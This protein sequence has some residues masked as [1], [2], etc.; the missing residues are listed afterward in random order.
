MT[1]EHL[2]LKCDSEKKSCLYCFLCNRILTK[3]TT[4]LKHLDACINK[5]LNEPPVTNNT[6][7]RLKCLLCNETFN[8]LKEHEKHTWGHAKK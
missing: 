1:T 3:R 2:N 6:S 7:I 8:S 5:K 4:M